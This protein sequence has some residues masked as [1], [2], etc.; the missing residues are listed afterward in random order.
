MAEV[1]GFVLERA[2]ESDLDRII[3]AVKKRRGLLRDKAAA[4]VKEG[5]PVT[6]YGLKPAYLNGLTGIVKSIEPG[7][8]TR[9]VVRLDRQSTMALAY[10][11]DKYASLSGRDSYDLKGIPV[12]CCRVDPS[13][14]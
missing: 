4:D 10:S 1:I 7:R 6:L 8:T 14:D 13:I 11:S 2:D 9:A 12:T 5:K 3:D